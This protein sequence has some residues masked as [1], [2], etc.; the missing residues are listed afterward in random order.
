M[1]MKTIYN[2]IILVLIFF[3][4]YTSCTDNYDEINTDTTRPGSVDPLFQLN[5]AIIGSS[6]GMENI[7]YEYAIIRQV[8]TPFRGVLEG[9]NS[10]TV[11]TSSTG[12]NWNTFYPNVIK[13]LVDGV[14]NLEGVAGKTNALS[15]LRIYKAYSFMVLTDTYGD[16]PYTEAGQGFLSQIEFPTYDTQESIYTDILSELQEATAAMNPTGDNIGQELLFRGDVNKWIRFGN[17]LLLRAAMRLSKVN[18][19]TAQTIISGI[20]QANLMQSNLDNAFIPHDPA[21][22]NPVG[23]TLN[24]SERANFYLDEI[25]VD[26]LQANNDPRLE[27][28][29]IRYIG[30]TSGNGQITDVASASAADQFGLPQGPDQNSLGDIL[31]DKGLASLYDFSQVDRSRVASQFSPSFILT[32]SQT[33]LLLAEA[34][35]RGWATGDASEAYE[36]GIRA[37]MR[38]FSMYPN[39]TAVDEADI[40]AYITA[41]PLQTGT[42]LEQINGEYWLSSFLAGYEGWANFRRSGFPTIDPNPSQGDLTGTGESFIRRLI[43]TDGEKTVNVD[44]VNTAIGRQG[45][46]VLSTR[47]WWD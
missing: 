37:H 30:A 33:M 12:R 4:S 40:D 41:N 6:P 16:I 3:V 5:Q 19:G 13:N 31:A 32:Y 17:S 10:N 25:F 14:A 44:N 27:K 22:A 9:A 20:N 46:D 7:I 8:H 39:S 28:I 2:K 34:R 42:E 35:F 24:G 36:E 1:K 29:A 15:A 11:N 38:Q 26:E 43:Y 47:F 21:Y 45:A 18:P 23:G